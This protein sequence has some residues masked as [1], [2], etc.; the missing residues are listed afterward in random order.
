MRRLLK[1]TLLLLLQLPLLAHAQD[2][3]DSE[4]R[5]DVKPVLCI[6]DNRNPVCEV[7]F[8]VVWESETTGYYCL[9]NDFGEEPL[10]CWRQAREGQTTDDRTVEEDFAFW[11]T[12]GE[13]EN[14]LAQVD[15]E[16][17]RLDSD[18]RRRRRRSRHVWDIN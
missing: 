9:F 16:V 11:M 6:I 5:L 15:V 18:D 7:S 8:L 3:A 10:R 14:R 2:P 12:G 17:L 4:L 1:L 13:G